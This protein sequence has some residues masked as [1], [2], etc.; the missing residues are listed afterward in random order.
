MMYYCIFEQT[1]KKSSMLNF[2]LWNDVSWVCP[3]DWFD[4][5]HARLQGDL[6]SNFPCHILFTTN[7]CI[8]LNFTGE[9]TIGIENATHTHIF[10]NTYIWKHVMVFVGLNEKKVFEDIW[11]KRVNFVLYICLFGLR[12][13]VCL[14][15]HGQSV[16]GRQDGAAWLVVTPR[17]PP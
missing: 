3:D 4:L 15:Q 8:C 9:Y 17:A 6:S 13:V 16:D 7:N 11:V 2:T 5:S 1:S 12:R 14:L 10:I